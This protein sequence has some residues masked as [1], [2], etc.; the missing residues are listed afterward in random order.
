[1]DNQTAD[2]TSRSAHGA[3]DV[4]QKDYQTGASVN[5]R[6]F[7]T[8]ISILRSVLDIQG[9]STA[10][11]P[12]KGGACTDNALGIRIT[13]ILRRKRSEAESARFVTRGTSNADEI[14][15]KDSFYIITA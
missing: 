2:N 11:T 4:V 8:M 12:K 5:E 9:Q 3:S 10:T 14:S 15:H 7:N 13:H 1:M 6:S